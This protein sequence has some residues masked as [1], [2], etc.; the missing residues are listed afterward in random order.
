[1]CS[2]LRL[3]QLQIKC[4]TGVYQPGEFCQIPHLIWFNHEDD[5]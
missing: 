2:A 1:M 5:F 3:S 4:K